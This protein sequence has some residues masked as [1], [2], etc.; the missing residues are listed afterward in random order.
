MG[1]PKR[2]LNYGSDCPRARIC[3]GY[4][5]ECDMDDAARMYVMRALALLY[6]RRAV[7]RAPDRAQR[8]TAEQKRKVR[9]LKYALEYTYHD[10]AN[11]TGVNN[12]GRISEI[13]NDLR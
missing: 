1:I 2:R 13:M 6:R 5:L 4:A 8:I 11:L 3:L 9:S 10:I 7:R 12:T